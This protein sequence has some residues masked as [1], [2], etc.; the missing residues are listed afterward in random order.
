MPKRR[1]AR[2]RQSGKERGHIMLVEPIEGAPQTVIV[3][4]VCG[5]PFSQQMLNRLVL[6]ILRHQVQLSITEPEPIEN[7]CDCGLADTHA[8]TVFSCL[9]IKPLRYSRFLTHSRYYP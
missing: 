1:R 6:K 3:E 8:S 2:P 9:L 4:H 5:D 7:H